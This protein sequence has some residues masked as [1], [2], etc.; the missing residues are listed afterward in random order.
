MEVTKQ[1]AKVP[2]AFADAKSTVFPHNCKITACWCQHYSLS[3]IALRVYVLLPAVSFNSKQHAHGLFAQ[4]TVCALQFGFEHFD[5]RHT[6]TFGPGLSAILLLL[7]N[8]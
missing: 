4:A 1:C 3:L 5:H 7:H 6:R 8:M 2:I